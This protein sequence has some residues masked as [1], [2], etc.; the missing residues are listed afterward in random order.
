MRL[1]LLVPYGYDF[2]TLVFG[3]LRSGASVVLVDPG[4]GRRH[5]LGC[6]EAVRPD[7]FVAI[8]A[9]QC[10]RRAL[11][12]RF[13]TARWN[14]CVGRFHWGLGRSVASL[15]ALG[16]DQQIELPPRALDD[17]AAVIFTSGSTGPPKGVQYTH[18]VFQ[19]QVAIVA[20]EY[21]IVPGEKDLACFPLFGLFD[22]LHGV[23]TIIPDMDAS[24]PAEV[25]PA[26]LLDAIDQW[27]IEQA[28]GSPALWTAVLRYCR[29]HGRR[30]PSLR[31]V[32]SAGA[33]V[34]PEVLE[35]LR[36]RTDPRTRIWTPYGATEALPLATIEAG[37]V[38][39]QTAEQTRRGDGICVGRRHREVDWRII[40]ISDGP[41]RRWDD[42]G[43]VAA[44]TIGELAVAGPMVTPR[45]VTRTDQN[46]LH[47]ITDRS[48]RTWHRLG[49]VGYLDAEDRFWFCGRKAHRVQTSTGTLYSIPCEA[50]FN[51][52]PSVYRSALVGRGVVGQQE[53][54]IVIEPWPE[55]RPR[56][57]DGEAR[58]RQEL[59]QLAAEHSITRTIVDV[60]IYP[61]SLPVD[62][63][64]NAKI[65]REQ[66]AEWAANTASG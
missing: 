61:K 47:K 53:P 31:R 13:P 24:R 55:Q 21:G 46:D 65:I 14:V 18:R 66:V 33:P 40:P 35:G 49:D 23:T 64:H 3:L 34:S 38:I 45:Y 20:R 26:R 4:M 7:G 48:Q 58:L 36:E 12:S 44:G 25:R 17:E 28:F 56:G 6:L 63:R 59:R 60:R 5:L 30:M 10:I 42:I 9:A 57:A 50:V 29:T 1:T 52:H 43:E 22:A 15:E 19:T 8:P 51:T 39:G 37:D 11:G 27:Q 16:R 62:P 41:I 32:M 2:I 54:V